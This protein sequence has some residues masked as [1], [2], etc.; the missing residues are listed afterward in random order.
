MVVHQD[1][2]NTERECK[3][4]SSILRV[5]VL[6]L[7]FFPGSVTVHSIHC[8]NLPVFTE[9]YRITVLT[10]YRIGIHSHLYSQ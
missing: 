6:I 3:N 10:Y 2:A 1:S 9:Y 5:S 7:I 4:A 8:I